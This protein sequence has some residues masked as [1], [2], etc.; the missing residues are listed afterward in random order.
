MTSPKLLELSIFNGLKEAD[1]QLLAGLFKPE[2]Y[3][4]D[5]IIF[6]QGDRADKLHIL[7][8]G[9]VAIR[10][11]PYDGEIITVSEIS[12]GNIFGWSSALGRRDYTSDAVAV[13]NGKGYSVRGKDL[14]D[15]VEKHP[16]TGVILL[17]RLAEVISDRLRGTHGKVVELLREG[18]TNG[19]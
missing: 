6:Q 9:Q 19:R 2:T 8:S 11:Q 18:M 7:T 10:F 16:E 14:R 5:Q 12:D 17:E 4:A 3:T 13:T 15:F 1:A